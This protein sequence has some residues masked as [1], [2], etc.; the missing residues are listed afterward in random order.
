MYKDIYTLPFHNKSPI[1]KQKHIFS[2]KKILFSK[3]IKIVGDA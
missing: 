3:Y 1:K 2:N